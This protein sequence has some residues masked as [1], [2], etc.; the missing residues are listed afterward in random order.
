MFQSFCQ[1]ENLTVV[2]TLFWPYIV[3]ILSVVSILFSNGKSNRCFNNFFDLPLQ[4]IYSLCQFF[5]QTENLTVVWRIFWPSIAGNLSV[6][7]IHFSN[8][9][10]NLCFNIFL[11]LHCK[12]SIG[13]LKSLS[14]GKS[15]HCFNTFWPCIVGSLSVVSILF[16]K[17]KSHRCFNNCLSFDCT[18]SIC[19]FNSFVKQ[20]ISPLFQRVFG[21]VL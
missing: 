2:V 21:F 13:C 4:T 18:Q 20:N 6:V 15:N 5:C 8:G 12:D 17:R 10:P 3:G 19:C 9:K 14:N 11:A 1:T 7:S 16:W